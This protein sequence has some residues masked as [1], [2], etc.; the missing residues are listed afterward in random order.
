MNAKDLAYN[1]KGYREESIR[2][3]DEAIRA[4]R[5]RDRITLPERRASGSGGFEE[6]ARAKETQCSV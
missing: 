2:Q 1:R 6:T 4:R 3:A 5:V